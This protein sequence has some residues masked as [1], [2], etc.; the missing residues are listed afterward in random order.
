[1]ARHIKARKLYPAIAIVGEGIVEQIYFTQLKQ[2]EKVNFSVKP[3][4][5]KHPTAQ[6]II[7]KA[8]ELLSKEYDMVFCIIDM[9]QINQNQQSQVLYAQLKKTHQSQKLIFI[10]NN[11][12]MEL[13]FLLHFVE[14]TRKFIDCTQPTKKLKTYIADYEKSR[15]FLES[16]QIYSLLKPY[17]IVACQNAASTDVMHNKGA[18]S[19]VYK[20]L[21]FLKTPNQKS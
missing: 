10:E 5:P 14:T 6:S 18:R 2:S 16:R 17:Q 15:K 12:C 8:H 1:M 21:Q 4:L 20:V 19:Q 11:P 3:D 7:D 13:W 9:D